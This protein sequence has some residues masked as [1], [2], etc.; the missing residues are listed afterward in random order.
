MMAKNLAFFPSWFIE[1]EYL[2]V[3]LLFT[4]APNECN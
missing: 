2:K 4:T 3:S 1:L